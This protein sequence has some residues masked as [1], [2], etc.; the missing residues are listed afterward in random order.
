MRVALRGSYLMLETDRV[1]NSSAVRRRV[2]SAGID[3]DV[4]IE[5]KNQIGQNNKKS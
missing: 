3:S 2:L 5:G 4:L 1:Q